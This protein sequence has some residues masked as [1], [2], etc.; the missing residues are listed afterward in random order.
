[1]QE[2]GKSSR[3]CGGIEELDTPLFK[4][5][6][7]P[8]KASSFHCELWKSCGA[9][10]TQVHLPPSF[11]G[12]HGKTFPSG[13]SGYDEMQDRDGAT[14][15]PCCLH[16]FVRVGLTV[17]QEAYQAASRNEQSDSTE[18]SSVGRLR[19]VGRFATVD[20]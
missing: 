13:R 19:E 16:G 14:G 6:Q 2:L 18:N 15:Q 12:R 4:R 5:V 7:V 1:M 17:L 10:T 20:W 8:H 11:A 3:F 9:L